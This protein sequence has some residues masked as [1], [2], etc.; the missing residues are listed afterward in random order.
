M[1]MNCE[2]NFRQYVCY[3]NLRLIK[4][5][6]FPFDSISLMCNIDAFNGVSW[7]FEVCEALLSFRKKR[8]NQLAF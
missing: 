3:A 7:G 1:W 6:N 4:Q 5:A 2:T 8:K